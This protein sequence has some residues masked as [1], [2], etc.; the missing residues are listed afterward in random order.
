MPP[1]TPP[2]PLAY[3]V[4]TDDDRRAVVVEQLRTLELDDYRLRA[5]LHLVPFIGKPDD[6]PG[7]KQALQAGADGLVD[8]AARH[9]AL[10]AEL[11][12]LP[13]KAT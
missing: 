7:K 2:K 6:D 5:G 9:A 3:A 11:A 4:T 10:A 13:K 8:I 12:K 1:T